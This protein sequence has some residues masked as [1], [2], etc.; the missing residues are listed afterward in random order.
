MNKQTNS[1]YS[2]TPIVVGNLYG[3]SFF[4]TLLRLIVW[5]T[6]IAAVATG[7]VGVFVFIVLTPAITASSDTTVLMRWAIPIVIVVLL[8]GTAMLRG[9]A[10]L[11]ATGYSWRYTRVL[12]VLF[13][14]TSLYASV[15]AV[16]AARQSYLLVGVGVGIALGVAFHHFPAPIKRIWRGA[17]LITLIATMSIGVGS[18]GETTSSAVSR[19]LR[20]AQDARIIQQVGETRLEEATTRC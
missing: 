19:G 9:D 13:F 8:L 18:P 3:E 11:R 5:T 2:L 7:L 6:S 17:G 16:A 1:A 12:A 14:C 15:V 10:L 4:L 20:R